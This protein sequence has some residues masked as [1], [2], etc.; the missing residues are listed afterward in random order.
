MA[1]SNVVQDVGWAI[2]TEGATAQ[3]SLDALKEQLLLEWADILNW[4]LEVS[5]DSSEQ[6]ADE[7]VKAILRNEFKVGRIDL[8]DVSVHVER[9]D[10]QYEIN[11]AIPE[12]AKSILSLVYESN[13]PIAKLGTVDVPHLTFWFSI[14]KRDTT[15]PVDDDHYFERVKHFVDLLQKGPATDPGRLADKLSRMLGIELGKASSFIDANGTPLIKSIRATFMRAL[16]NALEEAHKRHQ[17]S[18]V[19]DFT[20]TRSAKELERIFRGLTIGND[21]EPPKVRRLIVDVVSASVSLDVDLISR[22]RISKGDILGGLDA[23]QKQ[24]S[25]LFND[26]LANARLRA[27]RSA[28]SANG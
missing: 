20:D 21:S 23:A 25:K 16:S 13:K 28:W 4:L 19:F 22:E 6:L 9:V 7:I 27:I 17:G 18:G 26:T 2:F 8:P 11:L 12:D 5:K 24:G 10:Y 15:P 1:L 14:T 3:G